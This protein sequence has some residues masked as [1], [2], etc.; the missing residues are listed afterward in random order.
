MGVPFGIHPETRVIQFS[1]VDLSRDG[2]TFLLLDQSGLLHVARADSATLERDEVLLGRD[3][4]L[5]NHVL[6]TAQTHSAM[7]V[8]FQA[9]GCT[10]LQALVLLHPQQGSAALR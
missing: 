6:M 3:A 7:N 1:V 10:Q 9:V 4:K 5:G 8:D 2:H